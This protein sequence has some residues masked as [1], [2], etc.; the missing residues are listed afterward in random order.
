M[1]ESWTISLPPDA[2]PNKV[3]H[4]ALLRRC[5]VLPV[6]MDAMPCFAFLTKLDFEKSATHSKL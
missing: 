1:F 3:L 5:N 6:F 4:T 2:N